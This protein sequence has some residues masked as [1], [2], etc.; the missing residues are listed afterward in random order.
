M[1]R[2]QSRPSPCDFAQDRPAE[3]LGL[4]G[5]HGHRRRASGLCGLPGC[6]RLSRAGRGV[7]LAWRTFCVREAGPVCPSR[8]TWRSLSLLRAGVASGCRA[9]EVLVEPA[10][11][12]RRSVPL[13]APADS[14]RRAVP[15]PLP[16]RTVGCR[17]RRSPGLG[18]NATERRLCDCPRR[19]LRKL[20]ER[21]LSIS[22]GD[23]L[24]GRALA[25]RSA[26]PLPPAASKAA[27]T[28]P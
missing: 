26:G 6:P 28:P 16:V 24:R 25:P 10:V 17:P 23:K 2:A 1:P 15:R 3:A 20:R 14:V 5:V 13:A 9:R 12:S 11:R 7:L 4:A 18:G 22:P 27:K 8:S 21:M 19:T